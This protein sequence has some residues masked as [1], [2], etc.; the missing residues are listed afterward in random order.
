MNTHPKSRKHT[1][2]Q[3][4][5]EIYINARTYI[6][7][8]L[9]RDTFIAQRRSVLGSGSRMGLCIHR[10]PD[11]QLFRWT[12]GLAA[13]IRC[14]TRIV[15]VSTFGTS[16]DFQR[17]LDASLGGGWCMHIIMYAAYVDDARSC[18]SMCPSCASRAVLS[19]VNIQPQHMHKHCAYI[20]TYM[21]DSMLK[22]FA[23]DH[24]CSCVAYVNKTRGVG[25]YAFASTS[26]DMCTLACM[27]S[28]TRSWF[29]HSRARNVWKYATA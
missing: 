18:V 7:P 2:Q 27:F 26:G 3:H 22:S 25:A 19:K 17:K 8:L 16:L 5:R 10:G 4:F 9:S 14:W 11:H 1:H 20:F 29:G 28:R 15:R 21:H 12:F 24:D 13:G 23:H 6:H